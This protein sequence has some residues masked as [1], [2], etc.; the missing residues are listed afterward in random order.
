MNVLS[1]IAFGLLEL[2][3]LKIKEIILNLESHSHILHKL[4]QS[5]SL[6]LIGL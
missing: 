4:D 6:L 5:P 2:L 1:V 3:T